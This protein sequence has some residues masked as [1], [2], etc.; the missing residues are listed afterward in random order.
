MKKKILTQNV[1]QIN[2]LITLQANY[3]TV[4]VICFPTENHSGRR[5]SRHRWRHKLLRCVMKSLGWQLIFISN[6]TELSFS[7][8][9][10]ITDILLNFCL[11]SEK[12]K[13]IKFLPWFSQRNNLSPKPHSFLRKANLRYCSLYSLK[14][15]RLKINIYPIK[16]TENTDFMSL[17]HT[18]VDLIA[19]FRKEL[20]YNKIK[21]LTT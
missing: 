21:A 14:P 20:M 4:I 10:S 5:Q 11:V 7:L 1:L 12:K 9:S 2:K 13:H 18:H 15:L 16:F 8:C 3:L 17:V 6:T 19:L